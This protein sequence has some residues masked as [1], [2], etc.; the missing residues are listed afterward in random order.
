MCDNSFNPALGFLPVSTRTTW[1]STEAAAWS[2]NPA[3]GFLPVS[4]LGDVVELIVS[5]F[6]SRSG[7]SPRL[8][9]PSRS[10]SNTPPTR[11]NPALGFLPVSTVSRFSC[12]YCGIVFQSRSGFSP[13]LDARQTGYQYRVAGF[14]P[15]LGFL[16]VSTYRSRNDHRRSCR[17]SIPLWVFSPSRHRR[18]AP[19]LL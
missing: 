1:A 8:D 3:L 5:V 2:F 9:A 12:S 17:V 11:F 14:N 16:P 7:F 10:G 19:V 6:Q 13:R 4:T 15:A 18:S